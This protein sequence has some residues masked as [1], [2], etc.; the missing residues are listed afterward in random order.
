MVSGR[1]TAGTLQAA[2]GSR[3]CPSVTSRTGLAKLHR[4]LSTVEPCHYIWTSSRNA[5][6]SL[7]YR[8]DVADIERC[9]VIA[10]E[11]P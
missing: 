1:A 7:R 3:N 6:V 5:S 9:S 8:A 2:Q 11:N 4:S 10:F